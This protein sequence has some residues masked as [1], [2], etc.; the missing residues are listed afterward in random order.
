VR[1]ALDGADFVVT[2]FQIGGY[3]PST[4]IDFDIPK[5]YGLRQTIADTL[6][7]GG[8][9]RG[10]G[11]C[12]ISGPWPRTWPALPRCVAPAIREPDGDQH[13]GMAER[14]PRL[15]Q[16]GLC[17]SVQNTVEEIAHDLDLP[18]RDIRYRVAG[19][20]HV[21]FFLRW[22]IGAATSTRA[23]RGL[24]QGACPNRRS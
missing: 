11:P 10:L 7:V 13:L 8:I 2:A 6:G 18:A 14:F 19:V 4:V 22:S 17:H 15:K 21:A 20:N 23:A 12:R 24:P 3:R 1:A 16:A 9:M 5:Q